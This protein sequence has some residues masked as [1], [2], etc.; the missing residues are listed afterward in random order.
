[1]PLVSREELAALGGL[2]ISEAQYA[3]VDRQARSMI[4]TIYKGDIDTASGRPL[5]VLQAVYTSVSLRLYANPTGA[6]SV[7]LGSASVTLGGD[8]VS[9]ARPLAL[10]ADERGDLAGLAAIPRRPSFIQTYTP[11]AAARLPAIPRE[12]G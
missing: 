12:R 10:T 11:Y 8:D 1:M 4:A 9:I 2:S 7:S 5:A 3:A 6:R